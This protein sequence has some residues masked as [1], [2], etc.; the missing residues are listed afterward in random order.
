MLRGRRVRLGWVCE[1]FWDF[2]ST[3]QVD[4]GLSIDPLR[5]IFERRS[6]GLQMSALVLVPLPMQIFLGTAVFEQKSTF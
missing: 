6:V 3:L 1:G 5:E 2:V 4:F